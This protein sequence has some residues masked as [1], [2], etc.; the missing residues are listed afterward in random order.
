MFITNKLEEETILVCGLNLYTSV[1]DEF[2][3]R[4]KIYR[5][6]EDESPKHFWKATSYLKESTDTS[7][8]NK[9]K[10]LIAFVW[11]GGI[12][13]YNGMH[14]D[15]AMDL[16]ARMKMDEVIDET[17]LTYIA[18]KLFDELNKGIRADFEEENAPE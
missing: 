8:F 10:V 1:Y 16:L 13:E 4:Y 9:V 5:K 2:Q 11:K 6:Q 18:N 14:F 17:E 7:L 12:V 15:T 3:Q